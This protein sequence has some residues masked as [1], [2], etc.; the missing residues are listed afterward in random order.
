ME[1]DRRRLL[2]VDAIWAARK[3]VLK[4]VCE[5]LLQFDVPFFLWK[6]ADFAFSLYENPAARPMSDL[7]ILIH[8]EYA[9]M[10]SSLLSSAGFRRFSP[11]PGLFTSGVIGETKFSR[12][13]FLVELHTHPLYHPCILPG[14]IPPVSALRAERKPGGYPAPGWPETA[15]YT[16]LHHADSPG[17]SPWQERD[18]QLMAAMLTDEEWEKLAFFSVRSGWGKRISEVLLACCPNPPERVVDV[19]RL[20]RYK[21]ASGTGRGTLFALGKLRG[22]KKTAFGAAVFYRALTGRKPGREC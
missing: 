2:P 11:G 8:E 17:L 10:A 20:N 5:R 9:G 16:L 7:D 22:W 12:G 21:K 14:R 4:T 18:I 13:G 19:L 1:P 6:G 3:E 15:L